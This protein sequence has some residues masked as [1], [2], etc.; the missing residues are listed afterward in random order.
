MNMSISRKN[1]KAKVWEIV[2]QIN[3]VGLNYYNLYYI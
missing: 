2:E 3:K 1:I